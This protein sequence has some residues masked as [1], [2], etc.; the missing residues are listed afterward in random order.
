M[1]NPIVIQFMSTLMS[2]RTQA[3][4]FHLGTKGPGSFAAHTALNEFYDEF[5]DI[6]DGFVES[7][8]G[9]YG[10]VSGWGNLGLQDFQSVEQ[11]IAYFTT[12]VAFIE[13]VRTVT[14]QDSYLQ[15]QIDEMIHLI[16]SLLYKLTNLQ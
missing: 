5:L 9:K 11:V 15:N 1:E 14:F 13:K 16:Y 2:A 12:L 8:Q 7:Y 3:H 4:V 6:V 10:I